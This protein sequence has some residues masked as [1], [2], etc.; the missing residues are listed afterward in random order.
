LGAAYSGG[1]VLVA[2]RRQHFARGMFFVGFF[3]RSCS[4]ALLSW[5]VRALA[6]CK[7]E[8]EASAGWMVRALFLSSDS[9]STARRAQQN[10]YKA[11][12]GRVGKIITAHGT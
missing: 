6:K 7:R 8:E 4:W 2:E 1:V 12:D 10:V 9:L 5:A 11:L 3:E